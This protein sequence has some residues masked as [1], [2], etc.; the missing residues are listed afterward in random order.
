ML[1]DIFILLFVIA[2]IIQV[3]AIWEKS[4][5]F[6]VLAIMF[7]L[8]LMANA[9]YIEVPYVTSYVNDTGVQNVTTGAHIYSD[10]GLGMLLLGFVFFDVVWIILMYTDYQNRSELP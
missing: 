9:L 2:F 4:I 8:V 7:W 1:S 5:I 3:I 10:V 6:S